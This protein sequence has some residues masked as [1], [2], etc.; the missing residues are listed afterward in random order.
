MLATWHDALPVFGIAGLLVA[1]SA[2]PVGVGVM[3]LRAKRRRRHVIAGLVVI[4]G[5]PLYAYTA[6]YLLIAVATVGCAPD[7][8]ECPI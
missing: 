8:F 5:L 6:L 1:A 3:I 4:A 2:T 7:A